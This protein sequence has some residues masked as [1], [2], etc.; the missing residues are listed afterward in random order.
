MNPAAVLAL[1]DQA[2]V[3]FSISAAGTLKAKGGREQVACLA[4]LI[5][6]HKD[7]LLAHLKA[8]EQGTGTETSL[9]TVASPAAAVLTAEQERTVSERL[10][11]IEWVLGF[12]PDKQQMAKV[13]HYWAEYGAYAP[14][15]RQPYLSSGVI[16]MIP[17]SAEPKYR[18]WEGGQPLLDTLLELGASD[19]VIDDRVTKERSPN[20]W[21]RWQK[22][23]AKRQAGESRPPA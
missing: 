8:A 11:W 1:A 6:E 14:D 7:A 12:G 17:Y 2:G 19:R 16:P 4:P 13:R 15:R 20:D 21:Q 22:I 9:G 23:K 3:S 10:W 18:H 5:K